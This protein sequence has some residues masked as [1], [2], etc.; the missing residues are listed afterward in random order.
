M[1]KAISKITFFKASSIFLGLAIMLSMLTSCENKNEATP[2]PKAYPKITFPEK[3]Y[4]KY[5]SKTCGFNFEY[6]D[7]A[8]IKEDS[9]FMNE[10]TENPCWFDII[11]PDF[12]ADIH[13]SYYEISDKKDLD[14]LIYDSFALV[15]KHTVKAQF[16]E[17]KIIDLPGKGGG[18]LFKLSGPVASPTQF[19]ITDSVHH[20]I[21]GSLY[22]NNKVQLDSMKI[23]YDFVD[24]DIEKMLENFY[25][26]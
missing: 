14:S 11:F 8:T 17:E 25:W 21:R 1:I 4:E 13:C 6:P 16:I 23:I 26:D 22:F 5:T 15:G 2:K 12:N 19:F 10:K 20:F 9:L 3:S 7:Y 24:E 18:I